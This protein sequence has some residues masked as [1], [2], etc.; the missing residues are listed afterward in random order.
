[1][2]TKAVTTAG[3]EHGISEQVATQRALQLLGYILHGDLHARCCVY[4]YLCLLSDRPVELH[5][6]VYVSVK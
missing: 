5:P 4:L 2:V 3:D 6:A 1:M